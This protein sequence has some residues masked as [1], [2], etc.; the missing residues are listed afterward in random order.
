MI[1]R[2]RRSLLFRV[3]LAGFGFIAICLLALWMFK[4]SLPPTTQDRLSALVRPGYRLMHYEPVGDDGIAVFYN[5]GEMRLALC[6]SFEHSISGSTLG[7]DDEIGN[8]LFDSSRQSEFWTGERRYLLLKHTWVEGMS[9]PLCRNP[10][11]VRVTYRFWYRRD[12]RSGVEDDEQ[13]TIVMDVDLS[14]KE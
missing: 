11:R 5:P 2:K 7:F 1:S 14:A 6:N 9:Y 10:L 8:S 12:Q 4:P 13:K 3:C